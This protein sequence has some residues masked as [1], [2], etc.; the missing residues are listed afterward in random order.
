MPSKV[1]YPIRSFEDILVEHLY[2]VATSKPLLHRELIQDPP[3]EY[4][5]LIGRFE[6]NGFSDILR[7]SNSAK[8]NWSGTVQN[9]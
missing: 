1:E 5:S 8:D 3:A 9:L 7:A 4:V 6:A 2:H